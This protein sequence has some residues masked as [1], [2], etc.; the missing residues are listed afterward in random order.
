MDLRCQRK[1]GSGA[2]EGV[3]VVDDA[4]SG[5]SNHDL[6]CDHLIERE[7]GRGDYLVPVPVLRN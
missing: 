7:G 1:N 4:R 3:K 5:L 2:E 6:C